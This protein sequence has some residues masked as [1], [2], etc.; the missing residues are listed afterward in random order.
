VADEKGSRILSGGAS[1][2]VSDPDKSVEWYKTLG[3]TVGRT[4][5]SDDAIAYVHM[6]RDDATLLLS[7]KRSLESAGAI[8]T[9]LK[10]GGTAISLKVSSVRAFHREISATIDSV[11]APEPQGSRLELRLRDP[12]GYDI[13]FF[14]WC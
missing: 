3:F 1:L 6:H 14:E 9:G 8:P 4:H 5:R 2:L 10:L 13:V 12:D 7:S 11:P